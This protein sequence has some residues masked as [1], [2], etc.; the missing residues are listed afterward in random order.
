ML[1]RVLTPYVRHQFRRTMHFSPAGEGLLPIPD[2]N[3]QY[4]LYIHVPFCEALCP[5]CSFHRVLLKQPRANRYFNALRRE[6]HSYKDKGFRFVDVYVGGGTPTVLPEQLLETLQLVRSLFPIQRI[7]VE[8]NPNHL[9]S[10]TFAALEKAGVDRLSVGVQSFDDGL[11]AEMG[12][13]KRYGSGKEIV[14]RLKAAYGVFN[15]L[16]VDMIFNLPHQTAASLGRDIDTLTGESIADQ[17]SFYPL[18]SAP[19][20]TRA[21]L[22][23]MG[24]VSYNRERSFYEQ[25]LK[26]MAPT[27]H[28][29]TAWC[30]ARERGLVDEYIVDHDDYVGVGSGAFSYVDGRFYSSSFSINRYIDRVER[31]R[32]AIVMGRKLSDWERLRYELLIKLFGLEL[33]WSQL[34]GSRPNSWLVPLWK[35]RL[36][37]QLI[38]ALQRD[39]N[40]YRLT[41]SGMY[42][43]VVMMREFLTGVNNFRDEMRAHIHAERLLAR[44]EDKAQPSHAVAARSMIEVGGH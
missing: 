35:E 6:I 9:N 30:F 2:P 33:D 39:G 1:E 31:G 12:R 32:A 4:L 28:P 14:A 15:T 16:N 3:K 40:R 5:F 37:L 36:A 19:S 25:I 20:T 21:M 27:Y 11:L 13:L 26:G 41:T 18:M 38:G 17:V 43:W 29:S 8:T 10:G 7:S 34:C 42:Y 24:R 23:D 22:K 44:T